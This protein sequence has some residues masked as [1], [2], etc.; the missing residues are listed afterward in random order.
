MKR[1]II[2]LMLVLT[3]CMVLCVPAFASAEQNFFTPPTLAAGETWVPSN[4]IMP[5]SSECPEGHTPPK[6]Y[7]YQ[8]YVKGNTTLEASLQSGTWLL[9]GYLPFLGAISAVITVAGIASVV[10]TYLSNNGSIPSTYYQ[11]V[12]YNSSENGYWYHYVFKEDIS[13]SYL[14]CYIRWADSAADR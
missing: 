10:D 11:Y 4:G 1:K 5:L 2:S 6:G 13:G 7:V 12:Y 9:L 3:M 14:D 8:G